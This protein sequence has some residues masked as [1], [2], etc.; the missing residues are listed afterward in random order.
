MKITILMYQL[1]IIKKYKGQTS[2]ILSG[3][4]SQEKLGVS[5]DFNLRKILNKSN[6]GPQSNVS[7]KYGNNSLIS[8]VQNVYFDKEFAYVASNSLPS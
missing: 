5:T 7:F 6:I 1:M 3:G 2:V 8:D 4:F